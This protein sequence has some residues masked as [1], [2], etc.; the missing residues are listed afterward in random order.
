MPDFNRNFTRIPN[1][2][3]DGLCRLELSGSEMRIML[4]IIRM[5]YGYNREFAELPLTV[6]AESVGVRTEHASRSLTKL[7]KMGIICRHAAKGI[8]PQT[9]SVVEDAI[10]DLQ[11]CA[12]VAENGNATVAENCNAGVAE[13]G[14]ATIAENGNHTY[15]EKKKDIKERERKPRGPYGNVF[16]SDEQFSSLVTDYGKSNTE[17]YIRK[18]DSY[19]QSTGRSYKDHEAAVRKWMD[20]DGVKKD[21]F[22]V[23]KYEYFIN[24][25]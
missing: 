19:M 2:I 23:S 10:S 22:D 14:N 3:L 17:N 12:T 1:D 8:K 9:I 25:F 7:E 24:R 15:K 21:D 6:I 11:K 20:D 5:T 13:I 4:C 18:V 16:L